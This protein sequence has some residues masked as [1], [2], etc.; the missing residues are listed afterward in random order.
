MTIRS[1]D[2]FVHPWFFCPEARLSDDGTVVDEEQEDAV[3]RR[4]AASGAPYQQW[5]EEGLITATAGS[6]IDYAEIESR[7]VELCERFNVQEIAFDPHMARQVQPKILEQGLPAADFRQVP[8]MMMP[9]YME[10]ER[11][12]L[13]GEFF[14]G[15]HPLLRH[16]FAN[17]VVKRSDL[18]HVVKVTKPSRLRCQGDCEHLQGRAVRQLGHRK[19][20]G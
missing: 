16:C 7:I 11:A 8:S 20:L 6:V 4:E 15:A 13:G 9:A 3:S 2:Y 10:L 14:H 19:P 5:T 18:C 1:H 17:V 12:F